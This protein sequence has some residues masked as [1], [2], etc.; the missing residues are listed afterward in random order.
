MLVV[1]NELRQLD[2]LHQERM[3]L[4]GYTLSIL[5]QLVFVDVQRSTEIVLLV[6]DFLQPRSPRQT[7]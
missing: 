2:P 1:N 4:S 6:S 7:L 3:N 5:G